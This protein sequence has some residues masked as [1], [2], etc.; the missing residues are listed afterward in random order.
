MKKITTDQEDK[1]KK[2][3]RYFGYACAQSFEMK[4]LLNSG[5]LTMERMFQIPNADS[6][7]DRPID[8]PFVALAV[9]LFIKHLSDDEINKFRKAVAKEVSLIGE[10]L[11][12]AKDNPALLKRVKLIAVFS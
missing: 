10:Y 8:D 3:S 9:K 4:E 6:K 7:Y 2:H 12:I 11:Q 1:P 5:K